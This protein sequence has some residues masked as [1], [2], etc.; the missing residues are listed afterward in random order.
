MVISVDGVPRISADHKDETG[1]S[2]TM[3][4]A[5]KL[6]AATVLMFGVTGAS[7]SFAG[8]LDGCSGYAQASAKQQQLNMAKKCNFKGTYWTTD[9]KKHEQYCRSMPPQKWKAALK[10]RATELAACK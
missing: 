6:A 5:I 7:Q 10:K 3:K 9:L 1:E 2:L 4:F 8:L